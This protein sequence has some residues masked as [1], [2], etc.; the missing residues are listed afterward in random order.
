[1][2]CVSGAVK[3][4]DEVDLC[5]M[6]RESNS[7]LAFPI[8]DT[9]PIPEDVQEQFLEPSM[10]LIP[11]DFTPNALEFARFMMTGPD[12]LEAEYHRDR[13]ELLEA[14]A[15]AENWGSA[16]EIPLIK[17]SIQRIED[18]VLEA[19]RL[20]TRRSDK[21]MCLTKQIYEAME[22]R[23]KAKAVGSSSVSRDS[24]SECNDL[25]KDQE[26]IQAQ[27][28]QTSQ[29]PT[30]GPMSSRNR[31][32]GPDAQYYF[33]QSA[34]GQHLY[35]HPLDIRILKHEYGDYHKFP[36]QLK[37]IVTGVQESTL[38]EVVHDAQSTPCLAY[39]PHYRNYDDRA[40][41]WVIYR[42]HVMFHFSKST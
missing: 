23:S 36:K 39:S 42:W 35:L 31:S 4:G 6:F 30:E 8:S 15:E 22:K 24:L 1:M 18:S 27:S 37:V 3:E 21:T 33:F 12:Y 2:Q 29:L 9:W 41:I 26:T 38:T 34:D 16:E 20:R 17:D 40:N 28:E 25:E 13:M 5:L 14:L 32:S 10:A 19:Q 7:M 11:W